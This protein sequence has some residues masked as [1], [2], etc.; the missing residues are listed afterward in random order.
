MITASRA[1]TC[2]SKST[3]HYLM[4]WACSF[5]VDFN[6]IVVF[7]ML[8]K[9]IHFLCGLIKSRQKTL[10][11]LKKCTRAFTHLHELKSAAPPSCCHPERGD[12]TQLSS[13]RNAFLQAPILR[14]HLWKTWPK[15]NNYKAADGTDGGFSVS[16]IFNFLIQRGCAMIHDTAWN[17]TG[18]LIESLSYHKWQT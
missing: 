4:I 16:P 10:K 9:K 18:A 3:S 13:R 5:H 1:L 14:V 11:N 17:N 2:S 12:W 15:D 7:V 6:L 8:E